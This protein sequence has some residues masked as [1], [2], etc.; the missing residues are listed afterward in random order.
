MKT[1][2]KKKQTS[3]WWVIMIVILTVYLLSFIIPSGQFQRDGRYAIPGSYQ[4]MEKVY[5][6]PF[7]ALGA[8]PSQAYA[9]FGKLFIAIL[10]FGGMMGVVNSTKTLD[11][12]LTNL[13]LKLK[14]KALWIIPIFIFVMGFIGALGSMI[15]TAILFIPLGLAVAKKLKTDRVFGVALII[16]GSYTGFM[17]SPVCMFTTVLGQEIAGLEPF[18]GM[19]F[20]TVVT[21]IN[22]AVVSVG[23]MLYAKR[24]QK[25]PSKYLDS[26]GEGDDSEE[27]FEISVEKLTRKQIA[28]LILFAGA[29]VLFALGGPV[30]KLNLLQLSSI[31]LPAGIVIG[32]ISGYDL[33][34]TMNKFVDGAKD[35]M[36]VLIF[37]ILS[38]SM[39]ATLNNSMIIDSIVYFISIPLNAL[40]HTAAA[41]GMFIANSIINVFIN[42][43]SGQTAIMM[44][45]M[46]PLSD[47]TN[48][49]R[50]M[51]LLSLQYGDGFTNLLAPTSV[52]LLAC[53]ALAKASFKEWYKLI[54]PIYS[55]LFVVMCVSIVIG[56]KMGF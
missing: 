28:V 34:K 25:N 51:A 12:A 27:A 4:E 36:P 35:M 37:M 24:T 44:P 33:D 11:I 29:F 20:R 31:M 19:F 54:V 21:I 1:A 32:F 18:S 52:N 47:V 43:G 42:S 16:I 13:I 26:F 30:F 17:S 55:V 49:T 7:E 41:I 56:S 8:V 53:L 23:L 9:T 46:A 6:N 10:I 48:V 45:I 39:L 40:G 15:S 50:Q 2:H 14:D 38:C 5:L 22:L 3:M